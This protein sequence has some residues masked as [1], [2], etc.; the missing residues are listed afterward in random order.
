MVNM[1]EQEIIETETSK[2]FKVNDL[3]SANWAFKKINALKKKQDEI[4][5]LAEKEIEK[6]EAWRKQ[7][8]E[9]Y[10][11]DISFF[12]GLL[13]E[14]YRTEKEKD[15]KFKLTSP[16][17]KVT[18][19]KGLVKPEYPNPERVIAEL[20][21]RGLISYIRTKE[22]IDKALIKKDFNIV[23]NQVVDVNGEPINSIAVSENPTS[24]S[25]KVED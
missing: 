1:F 13:V 16:Y 2:G 21:E 6:I 8:S 24:Y 7:N 12:E 25:V 20:K 23:G 10:Q 19:R 4:N 11:N 9:S 5:E 22:E 15:D 17:G 14:Y 3:D 18:S